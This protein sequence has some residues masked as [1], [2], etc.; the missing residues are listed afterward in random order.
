MTKVLTF[1]DYKYNFFQRHKNISD[2]YGDFT[3]QTY[4]EA[5]NNFNEFI[6]QENSK[7]LKKNKNEIK[8]AFRTFDLDK[9][10]KAL[11]NMLIKEYTKNTLY[12]DL[13][14]WLRSLKNDVYEKVSYYTARLMYSLNSY[15]KKE[16]KFY[17]KNSI[18]YRGAKTKFTNLLPFERAI[19]KVIAISSFTS[20]TTNKNLASRWSGR[21]KSKAIYFQDK[22]F[23]VI[24]IIN[25]C[26][27][28]DSIPCGISIEN[29]SEYNY[30]N[31]V[32]FQPFTFYIVKSVKFNFNTYT[33]DIE[34]E[35]VMKK[36]ILELKIKKGKK[37]SYDEKMKLVYIEE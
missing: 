13:N 31:E 20:T 4:N 32:L 34:L 37:V 33:V 9:D 3:E 5:K 15:G 16:K 6:N 11:D 18:I 12:G 14:N 22:K 36:E 29:I 28:V 10:L 8:D 24:Y 23:S 21:E 30:E 25:N 17:K 27:I 2:Y 1:H 26:N 19:G 7:N 35:T